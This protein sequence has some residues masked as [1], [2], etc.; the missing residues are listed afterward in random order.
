MLARRPSPGNEAPGARPPMQRETVLEHPQGFFTLTDS[1]SGIDGRR[2]SSERRLL[3]T[4][5]SRSRMGPQD[6]RRSMRARHERSQEAPPPEPSPLRFGRTGVHPR[7]PTPQRAALW[8]ATEQTRH[9]AVPVR[10]DD[11]GRR[12]GAGTAVLR[13]AGPHLRLDPVNTNDHG[14]AHRA[15][16]DN[17]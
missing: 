13:T 3:G 16:R 4:L 17:R 2:P 15:P 1:R 12:M 5:V 9:H 7:E 6:R 8:R 14:D 10:R 11:S